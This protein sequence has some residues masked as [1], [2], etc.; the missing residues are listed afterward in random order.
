MKGV[1]FCVIP[2][3]NYKHVSGELDNADISVQVKQITGQTTQ[4]YGIGLRY[5]PGFLYRFDI[6]SDGKWTFD[7]CHGACTAAVGLTA[8]PAIH[9][10]LSATNT[11]EVRAVG[12]HFD[13]FINGAKMGQADDD[14]TEAGPA[15][16]DA[17]SGIEVVFNNLKITTVP[18]Q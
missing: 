13:F 5:I 11:L 6:T 2:P 10:G 9:K 18:S 8:N 1:T 4:P 7:V 14:T 17:S 15:S 3:E 12:S 16:L